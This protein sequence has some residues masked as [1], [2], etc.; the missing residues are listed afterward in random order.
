[1]ET[2][3]IHRPH[4]HVQGIVDAAMEGHRIRCSQCNTVF[5]LTSVDAPSPLVTPVLIPPETASLSDLLVNHADGAEMLHIPAGQFT[6]GSTPADIAAIRA[7]YPEAKEALFEGEQPQHLVTL[8]DYYIYKY[9]VTVAQYRR[10]AESTGQT[11]PHAPSWPLEEHQPVINVS[12]HEASSYAEW[13]RC[14]LAH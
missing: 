4:C 6:M 3:A 12:W 1:M 14:P 13:G 5:M 10:F 9:P 2:L 7:H 11:P 8:D